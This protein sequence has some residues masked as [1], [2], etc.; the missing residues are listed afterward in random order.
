MIHGAESPMMLNADPVPK[1]CTNSNMKV[2]VDP[3]VKH[4][5]TNLVYVIQSTNTYV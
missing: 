4:P 1:V 5:P 3:S 2:V